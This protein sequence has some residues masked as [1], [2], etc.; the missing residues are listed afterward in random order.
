MND[1]TSKLRSIIGVLMVIVV[2]M[3][4]YVGYFSSKLGFDAP[5]ISNSGKQPTNVANAQAKQPEEEFKQVEEVPYLELKGDEVAKGNLNSNIVLVEFTDLQCPFCARFHPNVDSTVQKNNVKLVTKHFPLSFHQYAKDY[6]VMFECIA[7]NNGSSQAY[8][9]VSNLFKV[10]MTK[11]G[12]VTLEDGLNEAKKLGLSDSSFNSCKSDS[13]IVNKI[14]DNFDEGVKIGIN[15]TPA[16]YI[17]NTT[18]KKAVRVN[19]LAD[20]SVLQA[21]IEKIK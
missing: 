17:L 11:Q 13:T 7:K 2:V 9:F 18:S 14:K 3:A 5:F 10:N 19:G 12:A 15:G 20:E 6:S 21:E 16:L 8:T 1:E 4:Y